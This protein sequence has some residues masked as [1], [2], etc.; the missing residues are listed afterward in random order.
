VGLANLKGRQRLQAISK[1]V[2]LMLNMQ[3]ASR[4]Y[5]RPFVPTHNQASPELIDRL[6]QMAHAA[7]AKDIR[8]VKVPPNAIFQSKKIPYPYQYLRQNS[9]G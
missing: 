2:P 9:D 1:A 6:E 3:I 4:M 8:Y 5:D 7:G